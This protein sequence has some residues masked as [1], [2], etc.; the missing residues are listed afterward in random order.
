MNVFSSLTV[1]QRTLASLSLFALPLGVLFYFNLDQIAGNITFATQ[2]IAGNQTQRPLVHLV[3]AVGD[4]ETGRASA[5]EVDRLFAQ[6]KE[7]TA[8]KLRTMWQ[9][10]A[11]KSVPSG[12][13]LVAGL[14]ARIAQAGDTSNLTLDP[15]MDS[16][17]LADV[18]S[19]VT[20][21]ALS[22]LRTASLFLLPRLGHPLSAAECR[23]VAVLAAAMQESD[24]ERIVG[25]LDTAFRENAKAPRGPSPTLQRNVQPAKANYERAVPALLAH[26]NALAVGQAVPPAVLQHALAGASQATLALGQQTANELDQVLEARIAGFVRYRWQLVGGTSV[27]L[28]IAALLFVLVIRGITGP[29]Q[30]AITQLEQVAQGDLSPD[31]PETIRQRGDEIGQFS[32]SL[33][34]MLEALRTMSGEMQGGVTLLAQSSSRLLAASSAMTAGSRE[35]SDKAGTVAAAAEQM[36]A[37]ATFVASGMTGAA[38]NLAHVAE[39]T[40]QMTATIGEIA[41]NSEKA[42]QITTEAT[43]QAELV[44]SQIQQ[45]GEAAHEIGQV[46]EAITAISSQTNLLALNATIEAAR[47]GAAG[48]GF[49]VVANE[50]K[51]LAQQTAIATEDI[52]RRI[53]RVQEST[54]QGVERVAGVSQVIGEVSH[55]VNTIA[56][57]IEEQATVTR[58]ISRNLGQASAGVREANARVTESTAAS[59]EIARDIVVVNQA[60]REMADSGSQLRSSAAELSEVSQKLELAASRFHV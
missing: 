31:I 25:D 54:A 35:A 49:A 6:I 59:S 7:P 46:T 19:V 3:K 27:A 57:A 51:G 1:G 48:K 39:S 41:V 42:R 21:Q 34:T 60:A 12:D 43:R 16:Y 11:A 36:S 29:L 30:L 58:D 55:L 38:D 44:T 13:A 15:E 10:L 2:E 52:R 4:F 26:L 40:A 17:Y 23:Q 37:N 22:R 45:L 56:A 5:A 18:T 32:R 20:A 28:A 47:A 8:A 24:Y 53:S 50:I 9:A 33:Q 14:R